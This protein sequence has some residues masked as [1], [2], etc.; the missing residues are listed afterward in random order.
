[1]GSSRKRCFTH[2]QLFAEG[3]PDLGWLFNR[4]KAGGQREVGRWL[5][6]C[7]G[8]YWDNSLWGMLF[9]GGILCLFL[10]LGLCLKAPQASNA[11]PGSVVR[12]ISR[13]CNRHESSKLTSWGEDGTCQ[14]CRC[15][16]SKYWIK[17]PGERDEWAWCTVLLSFER[18]EV[19]WETWRS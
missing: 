13:L 15:Q 6:I 1:M 9:V 10:L 5:P 14:I 3:L 4:W 16:E 7:E 18:H 8:Q 17:W 11:L 19:A 2:T 12:K